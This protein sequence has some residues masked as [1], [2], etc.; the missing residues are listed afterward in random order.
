[1]LSKTK[2]R[3]GEHMAARK[4]KYK[5]RKD[6]LTKWAQGNAKSNVGEYRT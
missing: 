1:M 2:K 3:T 6:K 5:Q 4:A